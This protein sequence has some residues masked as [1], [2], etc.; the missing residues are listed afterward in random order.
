MNN[1]FERVQ[2][3]CR[4]RNISIAALERECGLGNA[5]IKKWN[6]SVPSGDRLLKV[7]D[8]FNVSV[9]YLL[10]RGSDDTELSPD[11]IKIAR[12]TKNMTPGQRAKLLE[13]ARVMFGNDIE[14][15]E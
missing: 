8:Y 2:G 4:N 11:V 15:T 3:L 1:L 10:G 5:T 13:M 9:D 12:M 14:N 6:A 7:A